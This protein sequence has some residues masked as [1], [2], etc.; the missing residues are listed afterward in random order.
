MF[1]LTP[2]E[3]VQ[4]L[5]RLLDATPTPDSKGY[6]TAEEIAAASKWSI[7]KTRKVLHTAL[8]LGRL[9]RGARSVERLDGRPGTIPVYRILPSP[10]SPDGEKES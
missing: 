2:E 5:Q 3:I 10:E 8:S 9:G 6:Y 1:E 7:S 4:E